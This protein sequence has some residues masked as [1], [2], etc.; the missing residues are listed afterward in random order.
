MSSVEGESQYFWVIG[1]VLCII[2]AVAS[3]DDMAVAINQRWRDQ[4]PAQI[5]PRPIWQISPRTNPF[6]P[7]PR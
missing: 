7:P 2:G 6:D 3:M 4:A 5:M 1:V